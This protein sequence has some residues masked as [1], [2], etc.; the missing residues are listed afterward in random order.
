MQVLKAICVAACAALT[1][2]NPAAAQAPGAVSTSTASTPSVTSLTAAQ[3]AAITRELIAKWQSVVKASPGGDVA[4]WSARLTAAI[5]EGDAANVLRATTAPTLELMHAALT[6]YIPTAVEVQAAS[7]AIGNGLV[8]PQA[9]GDVNADLTFTPLPN[10]RCRIANSVV[11]N[12][13][14][15]AATPR[16]LVVAPAGSYQGQGGVGTIAGG[17]SS[18]DC[19]I[20][21]TYPA[22]YALSISLLSPAGNGTFKVYAYGQTHE[23]GPGILFSAGSYGEAGNLTVPACNT[24]LWDITVRASTQVHY[25][26]D[27][28]GYY[29]RPVATAL[30]CVTTATGDLTVAPGSGGN[31]VAPVCAAGYTQTSTNCESSTWMMPMVFF[32]SGTC[33]AL[34][35]STGPATLRASRTCCRV[36]GR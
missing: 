18:A 28:I 5:A 3:R 29:M 4:R 23:A 31:A 14:L 16:H 12:S 34:N 17:N 26:I 10:G 1:A 2:L 13:P 22:A 21:G 7:G 24:C 20:P 30:D 33:S 8:A 11:L 32:K 25:V 15:P 35:N 6:G 36:P 27:V 19:G 9:L